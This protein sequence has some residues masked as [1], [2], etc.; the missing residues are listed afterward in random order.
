[1]VLDTLIHDSFFRFE[2]GST[3]LPS[4]RVDGEFV[5]EVVDENDNFDLDSR[6]YLRKIENSRIRLTFFRLNILVRFKIFKFRVLF[7]ECGKDE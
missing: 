1:M 7:R 3:K 6:A 2:A 4:L 5:G